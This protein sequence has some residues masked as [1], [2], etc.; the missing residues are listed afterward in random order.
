MNGRGSQ[1]RTVSTRGASASWRRSRAGS[2][3]SSRR[4]YDTLAALKSSA[5]ESFAGSTRAPRAPEEEARPQIRVRA[6]VPTDA[7][8]LAD[9]LPRQELGAHANRAGSTRRRSRTTSTCAT[10]VSPK[11]VMRG[12]SVPLSPR[13]PARETH[14]RWRRRPRV[15]VLGESRALRVVPTAE[16]RDEHHRERRDE[17]DRHETERGKKVPS[18]HSLTPR[19]RASCAGGRSR[20][21]TPRGSPRDRST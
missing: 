7:Y 21:G 3:C 18:P 9:D 15:D 12:V 6:R 17:R 20:R 13:C 2:R 5:L 4:R 10:I 16:R 1:R 19:S 14:A 11:R 8:R